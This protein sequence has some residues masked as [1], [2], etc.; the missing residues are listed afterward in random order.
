MKNAWVLLATCTLPAFGLTLH[1]RDT[2]AVV[3]F[4]I[5][6][7]D[8]PNPVARDRARRKRADTVSVGL[9]NEVCDRQKKKIEKESH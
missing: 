8:V 5:K 2:P 1:E 4:D 6:R 9:D 3:G 7:R